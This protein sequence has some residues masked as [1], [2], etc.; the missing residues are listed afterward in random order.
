M[1][2]ANADHW[3]SFLDYPLLCCHWFYLLWVQLFG[4]LGMQLLPFLFQLLCILFSYSGFHFTLFT[5]LS[6]M[7]WCSILQLFNLTQCVLFYLFICFILFFKWLFNIHPWKAP[8]FLFEISFNFLNLNCG[9]W[10]CR[11]IL[12][13][14]CPCCTCCAEL[15][16]VAV[17]LVKLP[18][19]VLRWFI[20]LIPC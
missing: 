20:S 5:A 14:L 6:S 9:G 3:V 12:S 1:G 7:G 17:S 4:F 13:C 15:A 2:F 18:V 8:F 10:Q 19:R 16:N 11:S